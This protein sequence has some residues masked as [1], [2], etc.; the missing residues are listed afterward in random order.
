[1]K[2]LART[3]RKNQTDIESRLWY[4]LRN[5]QLLG[6]KFRRQLVVGPYIVDFACLE[7][8]LVIEVDGGQHSEQAESDAKRT[9]YLQAAGYT[10]IRFWNN[11]VLN[12]ISTVLENI[13]SALVEAGVKRK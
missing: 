13:Y 5:R 7:P 6:C 4:H 2:E 8:K 3:L 10:V 1:M 9:Q 12:E 11:E